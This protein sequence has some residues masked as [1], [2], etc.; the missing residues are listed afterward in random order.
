MVS[1]I[2]PIYNTSKYI[3]ECISSI[4]SQ[5]YRDWELILVDD[6]SD[7]DSYKIAEAMIANRTNCYLYIQKNSGPSSARN[8]GISH[9]NGEYI[10]FVDSDDVLEV[11]HI[12]SFIEYKEYD[13]VWSG[14]KLFVDGSS[15]FLDVNTMTKCIAG[16]ETELKRMSLAVAEKQLFGWSVNKLYKRKIINDYN[17]R[18]RENLR[19]HEDELFALEYLLHCTNGVALEVATYKYRQLNNS[20]LRTAKESDYNVYKSMCGYMEDLTDEYI[21]KWG[22]GSAFDKV[23]GNNYCHLI[24]L[25]YETNFSISRSER[26]HFLRLVYLRGY[27]PKF[28]IICPVFT[29]ILRTIKKLY[30]KK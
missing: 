24:R 2:V 8:N 7:D 15:D 5:T 21:A 3:R 28:F 10:L 19:M 23:L 12:A 13:I 6:G 30:D 20:L 27:Y 22:V 18:F 1:V 4:F 26:I 16:N 17:I 25:M 11:N 14:L 29:D 9:A